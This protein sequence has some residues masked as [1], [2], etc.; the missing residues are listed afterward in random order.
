MPA[1]VHLSPSNE[2]TP[3]QVNYTFFS[4]SLSLPLSESHK[5]ETSAAKQPREPAFGIL[6]YRLCLISTGII[7]EPSLTSTS[8]L[9]GRAQPSQYDLFLVHFRFVL[10]AFRGDIV[11]RR[12]F[13]ITPPR[14]PTLAFHTFPPCPSFET[15]PK[16]LYHRYT[17]PH[18]C[19]MKLS[20][21]Y[22]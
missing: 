10:H 15:I 3:E 11:E 21:V 7:T 6:C 12:R 17:V 9:K 19:Y 5:T 1:T 20:K 22:F 16:A 8:S 18:V 13:P 2:K 14:S 4:L